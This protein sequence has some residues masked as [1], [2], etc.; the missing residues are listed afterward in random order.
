MPINKDFFNETFSHIFYKNYKP[1][2]PLTNEQLE[3]MVKVSEI[4]RPLLEKLASVFPEE[5]YDLFMERYEQM[6]EMR[7]EAARSQREQ[8]RRGR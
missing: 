7:L 1:L 3:R 6:Y 4:P 2:Y 8:E 5:D